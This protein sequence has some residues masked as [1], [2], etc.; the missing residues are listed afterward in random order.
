MWGVFNKKNK[1]EK[2]RRGEEK[3]LWGKVVKWICRTGM[4][5]MQ[6]HLLLSKLSTFTK[7]H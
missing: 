7:P 3:I 2:G 1:K 4:A 6:T 5:N